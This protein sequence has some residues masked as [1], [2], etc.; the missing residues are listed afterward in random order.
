MK[1][2]FIKCLLLIS[3]ASVSANVLANDYF[4]RHLD[5][6][7]GLSHNSVMDIFQDSEGYIWI[8]T[9]NGLNRFDGYEFTVFRRGTEGLA[10]NIFNCVREDRN[11]KMWIA[12]ANGLFMYDMRSGRFSKV[13]VD[14]S[15]K[16]F[17]QPTHQLSIDGL[18]GLIILSE[19][20]IFRRDPESGTISPFPRLTADTELFSGLYVEPESNTVYYST[21]DGILRSYNLS[22]QT[23]Q[24]IAAGEEGFYHM[25]RYGK[26]KLLGGT[27][28][29]GLFMIDCVKGTTTSI[30]LDP[31]YGNN[32]FIRSL[33]SI[34][35]GEIWAGCQTG[36]YILQQKGPIKHLVQEENNP[37]SISDN[38]VYTIFED[39]DHGLWIGSYFGGLDYI[40]STNN[41]F[42]AY[43]KESKTHYFPANSLRNIIQEDDG[44]LWIASEYNGIIHFDPHSGESICYDES[45]SPEMRLTHYN[46]QSIAIHNDC[47]WAGIFS[48][49][50]DVI[51]LKTGQVSKHFDINSEPSLTNNEVYSLY[52]DNHGRLWVGTAHGV[53]T[54]SDET[55]SF[56]QLEGLPGV[57]VNDILEDR[58]G[59]YWLATYDYGL[60]RYDP[61][62]KTFSNYNHDEKDQDSL[63]W[64]CVYCIFEHSDGSIWIGTS[65]GFCRWNPESAGFTSFTSADGLP[66]E[67]VYHILEDRERRLWLTTDNGLILFNPEI[68]KIQAVYTTADGLPDNQFNYNSGALAA[69]GTIWIGGVKGLVNFDPK[70]TEGLGK[71]TR[72]VKITSLEILGQET[73]CLTTGS[74]SIKLKHYQ[75]S[76]KIMFSAFDFNDLKEVGHGKYYYKLDGV[77]D[78]WISTKG[79]LPVTF[80]NIPAGRHLL[81]VVYSP[82]N[83]RKESAETT[84][85]IRVLRHPLTSIVALAIYLSL[86]TFL[87]Y[88]F[89][90]MLFRRKKEANER[91]IQDMEQ[92]QKEELYKSKID[93]FT[94][95]AHEIRTPLTLIKLPLNYILNEHPT[96]SVTRESLLSIQKNTDRLLE[97][98][99]QLL[100]FRKM[101]SSEFP[102][103][104]TT[105]DITA[106]TRNVLDHFRETAKRKGLQIYY[107]GGDS[108][109][110]AKVDK[111][112]MSRIVSNLLSNAV[113]HAKSYTRVIVEKEEDSFTLRVS[114][115]GA[116]IPEQY[117]DRIFE[118]FFQ[119]KNDINDNMPGTGIGLSFISR[120]IHLHSGEIFLDTEAKDTSFVVRIPI[121]VGD[122]PVFLPEESAKEHSTPSCDNSGE[123]VEQNPLP[124]ILVVE[125]NDE[126][127]SML[128]TYL[129]GKY[130]VLT[131]SNGN[132]ALKIMES[133][134]INLVIT[135]IMMP[136]MNG[137]ELCN[138]IKESAALCHIPV[139]MLTAK[140][141]LNDKIDGLNSGAEAYIEKPF[142]MKHLFAQIDSIMENRKRVYKLFRQ[143][144]NL[145]IKPL[146]LNQMDQKFLEQV[147]ECVLNNI[148]DEDYDINSLANDMSMSR[149]SLH[150][151]I[152]GLTG[153]T[154]GEFIRVIRLKKAAELLKDGGYRVNEVCMMVGVRSLSYFSKSFQK[155]F[156]ML[157]KDFSK[158]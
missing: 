63:P 107:N 5:R 113:K 53:F 33:K 94:S 152:K 61:F 102:I 96:E 122:M 24:T 38:S 2:F 27:H 59:I 48:R 110:Y 132:D 69:D 153:D 133:S 82:G 97:Q 16:F 85:A 130:D 139:I 41:I 17:D 46:V 56:K 95:I 35:N 138:R 30:P 25:I 55:D 45:A 67:L 37:Y 154:P 156:G 31:E 26:G 3:L 114:N 103:H 75:S 79:G 68:M 99:N 120:L 98:I 84:Y 23:E 72:D 141:T 60:F 74:D 43:F 66:S 121:G 131:A 4:I 10:A 92:R 137:I 117:K 105:C 136:V 64:N 129:T 90:M 32:I 19:G 147:R 21:T 89:V 18:G 140:A 8:S 58:N 11:K 144:Q 42:H 142:S 109:L 13:T 145:D 71:V 29:K 28:G 146:S 65:G 115:D 123:D 112:A 34:S 106:L 44:R 124:S 7:S 62:S 111:D 157:P 52:N 50:I 1:I 36:I 148:E 22:T 54:Y 143:T 149:S 135:D 87:I 49:G 125:D 77:N 12:T 47:L 39:R 57:L 155:M 86:A 101:E 20:K 150:R 91:K 158:M 128:K 76:L 6:N 78:T 116:P 80:N 9:L 93:F 81:R 151:K 134:F 70:A 51:N 119:L 100:D 88:S 127:R 40:P 14:S 104:T 83:G 108:P 73:P 118:T 126:L 15:G